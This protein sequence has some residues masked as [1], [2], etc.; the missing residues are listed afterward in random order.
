MTIDVRPDVARDEATVDA[1]GR[2]LVAGIDGVVLERLVGHH[3]DRGSLTQLIDTTQPFWSEGIVYAYAVT[4]RPGRIKGWGMHKL[5]AD[6]YVVLAGCLRVVLHDGRV[7]SSSFGRFAEFHFTD[8]SPGLLRIPAGVWHADQNWGATD[9]SFVNFPTRA[10]DHAQPD[11][12]R[13]DPH[14][15]TIPFD[16][17][18]RDS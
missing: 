3:D 2:R 9:V 12:H 5:Q 15:G 18:L 11:K 10:Y 7:D 13:I 17:T 14:A 8:A 6:R 4:I 1:R 16:F